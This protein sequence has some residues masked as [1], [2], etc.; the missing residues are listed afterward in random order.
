MSGF[1]PVTYPATVSS[2]CGQYDPSQD[3]QLMKTV[4]QI[5]QQLGPPGCHTYGS[6]PA[7]SGLMLMVQLLEDQ[8]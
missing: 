7:N 5:Q 2:E 1:T 8:H 6:A 4:G 3:Q